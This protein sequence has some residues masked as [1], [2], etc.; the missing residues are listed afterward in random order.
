MKDLRTVVALVQKKKQTFVYASN[1]HKISCQNYPDASLEKQS[2]VINFN[3]WIGG[4]I[5]IHSEAKWCELF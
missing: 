2:T 4:S 5:C 3:V 1:L